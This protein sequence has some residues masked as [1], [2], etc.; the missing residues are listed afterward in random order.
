MTGN[1]AAS[2]PAGFSQARLLVGIQIVGDVKD[3]ASV[4]AASA[5]FGEA[6]PW[7]HE[8]PPITC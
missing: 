4:L 6:R 5:A 7:A 1:P 2:A 8:R 3:E